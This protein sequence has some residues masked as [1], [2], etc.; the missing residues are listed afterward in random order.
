MPCRP[1]CSL[2]PLNIF[3]YK[4]TKKTKDILENNHRDDPYTTPWHTYYPLPNTIDITCVRV[5][6]S[7][8]DLISTVLGV[9]VQTSA[10]L[11][12]LSYA[13]SA[14]TINKYTLSFSLP[15]TQDN[16]FSLGCSYPLQ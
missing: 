13:F 15:K 16:D 4:G 1:L 3:Q 14:M 11:R 7:I 8:T 9:N 10:L 2:N 5:T 6:K 12:P